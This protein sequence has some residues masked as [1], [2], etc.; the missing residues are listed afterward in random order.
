MSLSPKATSGDNRSSTSKARGALNAVKRLQRS[1]SANQAFT[2]SPPL[3]R[4]SWREFD[5][6]LTQDKTAL[7]LAQPQRGRSSHSQP[8]PPQLDHS[9]DH[10]K[11]AHSLPI[12]WRQKRRSACLP[13]LIFQSA[14]ACQPQR[15]SNGLRQVH[16]CPGFPKARLNQPAA[17]L[18]IT[19]QAP[20]PYHNPRRPTIASAARRVCPITWQAKVFWLETVSVGARRSRVR[21]TQG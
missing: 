9:P 17:P 16:L 5:H 15:R 21:C 12:R 6:S 3:R 1:R 7:N 10:A 11:M 14:F 20:F 18:T 2:R 8:S 19:P 13:V 4:P